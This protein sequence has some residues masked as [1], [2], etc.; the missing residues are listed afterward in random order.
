VS[1]FQNIK[2]LFQQSAIYGLGHIIS[3]TF[4]FILLPLY[5]NIL[6]REE[7]G[8][9][10]ILFTYIA[11]LM[12]LYTYG[13]DAAFFSFYILEDGSESR[14]R[15]FS[16][17]F[18][19]I[20]ITS[21]VFSSILFFCAEAITQMLFSQGVIELALDLPLLIRL[22]SGILLFDS[23]SYLPFLIF[24]AEE[25]PSSFVFFKSF[26][27]L[28]TMGG[29]IILLVVLKWDLTG[30]FVSNL[31]ASG[32]VFILLCPMTLKRIGWTFSGTVLKKLLAFGAPFIPLN[33]AFV[34]MDMLDRPLLERLTDIKAAGLFNAGAKLGMF[35]ALLL[36]AFRYAWTPFFLATSKQDNAKTVYSKVFSYTILVCAAVFLLIS[37]FID[38]LVRIRLFGFV[39]IGEAYWSSTVIVPVLMLA[40]LFYA[41][42]SNFLAGMYLTKK[43]HLLPIITTAGMAGS[44][45]AN[46]C[47]IPQFNILGAA[48]A[49]VIAYGIM[50]VFI[51]IMVQRYYPVRYEWFRVL[52]CCIVTAVLFGLAQWNVIRDSIPA[53]MGLFLAFPILL[54]IL[55][56]FESSEIDRAKAFLA[57]PFRKRGTKP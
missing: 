54:L 16:T 25:K 52:K 24:R 26:H 49:R 57:R 12:I 13:L 33:L 36:A 34:I 8:L 19:T 27:I 46:I 31:L 3:R 22:A 53:K 7:Y 20:L 18:Y 28:L 37:L 9:V 43:T 55:G 40:S 11:I 23:L 4:H 41:A 17:A 14:K 56:F 21:A 32:F 1:I 44:I 48:W 35:M 6:P 50:A 10:G 2:R 5:T 39:L 45:I 51:Y 30:I 29:N 42:Y 38:H 47:L 15:I